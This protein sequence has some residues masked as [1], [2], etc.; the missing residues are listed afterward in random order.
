MN[1]NTAR[2]ESHACGLKKSNSCQLT[3]AV[4]FF[5]PLAFT[6]LTH[7]GW[8]ATSTSATK[9]K[10]NECKWCSTFPYMGLSQLY[11]NQLVIRSCERAWY[12]LHSDLLCNRLCCQHHDASSKLAPDPLDLHPPAANPLPHR[13]LPLPLQKN[14]MPGDWEILAGIQ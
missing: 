5:T 7:S 14:L 13:P 8:M 2:R 4:Q 1:F 3:P 11:A 9:G 12:S 10:S 6:D